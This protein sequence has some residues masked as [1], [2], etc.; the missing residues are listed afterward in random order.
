MSSDNGTPVVR[1]VVDVPGETD[2][3]DSDTLAAVSR[4]VS[5]ALD[6]ADPI[7]G[8]YL[9]E[10]STPGA[11]RE[12]KNVRHWRKQKGRL[13]RV[14]LRDK[15]TLTGRLTE[16]TEEGVVLD[17]DGEATTIAYADVKKARPRVEFNS[18]E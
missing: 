10:V 17:V 9:L 14:K 3:V 1:V 5:H 8:E 6:E 7:N 4:A 13:I 15:R 18:K 12:L 11:E 16:V 2:S